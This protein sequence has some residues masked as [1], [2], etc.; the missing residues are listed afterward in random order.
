MIPAGLIGFGY[1]G[2]NLLR[3]LVASRR[4]EVKAVAERDPARLEEA[5]AKPRPR[6]PS[7]APTSPRC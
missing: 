2:P 7:T 4:F 6:R 3:N 1:W 5:R